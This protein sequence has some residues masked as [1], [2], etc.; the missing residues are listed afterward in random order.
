MWWLLRV[1]L[2]ALGAHG[3]AVF[4]RG[5][6]SLLLLLLLLEEFNDG[7]TALH[8]SRARG[9]HHVFLD[10]LLHVERAAALLL[11]AFG[12]ARVHGT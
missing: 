3:V 1:F 10:H 7:E 12:A 2:E 8:A 5:L 11:G 9:C 6:V 4:G